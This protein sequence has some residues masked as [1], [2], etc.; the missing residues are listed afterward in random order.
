MKRTEEECRQML[1]LVEVENKELKNS[2]RYVEI[3]LAKSRELYKEL[4]K[5][6]EEATAD[7]QA[8]QEQIA[9]QSNINH[10]QAQQI[11]EMGKKL[12]NVANDQKDMFEKSK[13]KVQ[14]Y[15]N[16][17]DM[18][19]QE[20][21]KLTKSNG[22]L[23]QEIRIYQLDLD[24][25]NTKI[26]DIEEELELKS[27]E[28]NRLRSQVADLE[29]AVQDLYGSRKGEGSIHVEL[30]NMKADNERLIKLLRE[31]SEYQDLGSTEIMKKAKYLS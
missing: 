23:D 1:R 31:T 16:E 2:L 22:H 27:G 29:K 5:K 21:Q 4:T 3:Q 20:I 15:Q 19:E 9:R 7:I 11:E 13:Y 30:N 24:R 28:N 18:R 17:I 6:Y 26:A 12:D 14:Q 8:S 10:A 25:N